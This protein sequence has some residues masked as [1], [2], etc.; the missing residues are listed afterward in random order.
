[1]RREGY[2]FE[3]GQLKTG[4]FLLKGLDRQFADLPVRQSSRLRSRVARMHNLNVVPAKAGTHTLRPRLLA[5]WLTLSAPTDEGGY[6]SPRARGRHLVWRVRT[7]MNCR[8]GP[9]VPRSSTSD[10]VHRSSQ[11]IAIDK[12]GVSTL[13]KIDRKE[14]APPGYECATVIR[15]LSTLAIF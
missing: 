7:A 6:G 13:K 1:M 14:P 9:R 2:R 8:R 3:S 5:Q 11:S 4:I 15:H 10:C 12:Q